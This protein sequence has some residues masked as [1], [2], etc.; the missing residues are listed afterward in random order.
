[1]RPQSAKAKGRRLQQY[2]RDVL[3]VHFKWAAGDC[4][5]RSMGAAGTDLML[6]PAARRDFGYA[7]ECKNV[8]A[9][10][11]FAA[12]EQAEQ[13]ARKTGLNPLLVVK[14]NQSMVYV[15]LPLA[16]FLALYPSPG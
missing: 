9:L 2:V 5:S 13:H 12:M 6:S 8:E 16:D 15:A 7:I 11:F 3:T 10:N 4:E 1:M 14:R